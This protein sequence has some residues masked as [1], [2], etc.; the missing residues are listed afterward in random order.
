MFYDNKIETWVLQDQNQNYESRESRRAQLEKS[1][2]ANEYPMGRQWVE[3][4]RLY[5]EMLF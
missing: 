3:Y 1:Q 4:F 5:L 2:I